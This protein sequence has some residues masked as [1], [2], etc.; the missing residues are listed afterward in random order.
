VE[1]PKEFKTK[2]P[3]KIFLINNQKIKVMKNSSTNL[4]SRISNKQ[5]ENLLYEVKET[6]ASG[7]FSSNCRTFTAAE[8]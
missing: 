8:L 2:K 6:V 3:K 7:V 1:H 4:L 5:L